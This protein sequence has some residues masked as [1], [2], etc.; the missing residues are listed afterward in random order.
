MARTFPREAFLARLD[1]FVS[2]SEQYIVARSVLLDALEALSAHLDAVI[3]VGAQA[4]YL[5]TETEQIGVAPYTTDGDVVLDPTKLDED[6]ALELL[7]KSAGFDLHRKEDGSEEPGIWVE[8]QEIGGQK[9]K[10]PVDL[11]VPTDAAPPGGS[12]GAR[13]KGHSKRAARKIPGLEA[14]LLDHDHM[15]IASLTAVDDR[16][17]EIAIAGPM[18][19]LIAKSY[20]L[21]ERI[22][23]KARPDRIDDKDAGDA[24][25][26]MREADRGQC[27]ETSRA[28]I[29]H[30]DLG[31]ACKLGLA[32]LI[33]L[34]EAAGSPGT[35]MAVTYF[36][37]ALPEDLVVEVCT[38]FTANLRNEL[39]DTLNF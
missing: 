20:K 11:I 13:L 1:L 38:G 19:L 39:R 5:R 2:N 15:T 32:R 6:P 7:M 22:E 28:L 34:F 8:E 31:A 14:S 12:R 21:H 29:T 3:L 10:V 25:R 30:P 26:I 18:A 23:N 9:V 36:R 24:F 4:V 35:R 27:V 37:G 33:N 17:F 16:S